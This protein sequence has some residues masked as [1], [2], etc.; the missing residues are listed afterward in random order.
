MKFFNKDEPAGRVAT[1]EQVVR[2]K[3][4]YRLQPTY[5]EVAEY[6]MEHKLHSTTEKLQQA[7]RIVRKR[8][9]QQHVSHL[10]GD[11]LL[12]ML[13]SEIIDLL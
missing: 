13:L 11:P 10:Q 6:A 8:R 12:M 2:Q 3:P 5:E 1:M 4:N 7:Y 9:L